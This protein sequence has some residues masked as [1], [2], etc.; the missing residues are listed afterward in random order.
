MY[1]YT[2]V[3]LRDEPLMQRYHTLFRNQAKERE[4]MPAWMDMEDAFFADAVKEIR[5]D[6][7]A[8]LGDRFRKYPLL[9]VQPAMYAGYFREPF[10]GQNVGLRTMLANGDVVHAAIRVLLTVVFVVIPF[11]LAPIGMVM[12]V[13]QWRYH[14]ILYGLFLWVGLSVAPIFLEHRYSVPVHP[15]LALFAAAGWQALRDWRKHRSWDAGSPPHDVWNG[16][17]PKRP[18]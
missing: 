7:L 18:G 6:P 12:L 15:F 9:W 11:S 4:Q 2:Q 13:R 5:S 17:V 14:A 1:D 10:Q 3:A 16:G 8:Y